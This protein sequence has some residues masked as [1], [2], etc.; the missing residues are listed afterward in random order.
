MNNGLL[1]YTTNKQ[2]NLFNI[3]DY[4][5]SIAA[6]QYFK[7]T[8]VYISRERLDEYTGDH[9]KLIMNGW[10][11]HEP[12]HWPP[13]EKITPLFISFHI[14]KLAQAQMLTPESIEYLKRHEP[15]GCRDRNT[16]RLLSEKGVDS[17]FSGCLTLTLG[18]IRQRKNGNGTI[19]FTDPH[20]YV[21]KSLPAL[22]RSGMNFIA[23]PKTVRTICKKKYGRMTPKNLMLAS[24]F[25]KQYSGLF[26]D[27]VLSGAE[28]LRHEIE[29]DF[30]DDDAKFAYA[31]ELLANYSEAGFVVTSRIHCA[32]PCLGMNVP[33]IY[34][35][36]VNK[37]E[38]SSCRFDGIMELFHTIESDK[39]KLTTALKTDGKINKNFRFE[40]KDLHE[41]IVKDLKN[42]CYNFARS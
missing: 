31:R 24:Q 11:M 20:H 30:K 13:S 17:Y 8:D 37:P 27:E 28:Y 6:S 41:A 12:E 16:A 10:F 1:V 39:G 3:G 9:V 18:M 34:V 7:K 32:L 15:V 26:D 36:D 33:V 4:I 21:Q 40:N 2:N 29:D 25:H 35:N 22:F 19:Y 38:V 14:N 23:H 42:T 5:Q